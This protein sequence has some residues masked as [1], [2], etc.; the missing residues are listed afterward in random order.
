MLALLGI[1]PLGSI[2]IFLGLVD[3]LHYFIDV[4]VTLG[5]LGIHELGHQLSQ[6]VV[7]ALK[8]VLGGGGIDHHL[9]LLGASTGRDSSRIRFLNLLQMHTG[10]QIS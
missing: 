1:G 6:Q 7:S 2:F 10:V 5:V 9:G 8:H 3:H 4:L